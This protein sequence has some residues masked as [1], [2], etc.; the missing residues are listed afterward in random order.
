MKIYNLNTKGNITYTYDASGAKLAK[1][2]SDST[3]KHVTTTLY[4]GSFV[5]QQTDTTTTP[6][7]KF[8]TLQF[9]ANEE[10]RTRWAYHK[11]TTGATA[12]KFEYDF[13]EKDHLG[14]TAAGQL[15]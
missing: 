15:R 10:G 11:Y 4:I 1:V 12:Y 7:T 9:I 14:N 3:V 13:Y 5:Y 6:G 2:T 8:D